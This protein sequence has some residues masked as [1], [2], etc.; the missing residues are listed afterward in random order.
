[1]LLLAT[2]LAS[3]HVSADRLGTSD[4]TYYPGGPSQVSLN[5]GESFNYPW[6]L[7][8]GGTSGVYVN[9]TAEDDLGLAESASPSFAVL[10]VSGWGEID[11]HLTAPSNAAS[12]S[13]SLQVHFTAVN[14]QTN[15]VARQDV[16]VPVS[17]LGLSSADDPTGR[18]LGT[19]PNPLPS[20][21]D[22][23]WAA[24]VVSLL[25]WLG[26]AAALALIVQPI[27]KL[28]VRREKTRLEEVVRILRFPVFVLTL[29]YGAIHSLPILG[30]G[31]DEAL[32]P[33]Y[34]FPVILVLT[35][36]GYHFFRDVLVSYGKAIAKRMKSDIDE[37]LIPAIEKIGAVVIVIVGLILAVQSL[38]Y[39]IT[40]VLAGFGVV[41]LVIAFA[42]QDTVSNFFA[43][44]YIMLD[45]PFRT[46]DMIEIEDDVICTVQDIGLRTTKLY[47]GKNHTSIIMP[48]NE[49]A[50][51]K[52]VNYV[53]PSRHFRANVKV[54]VS[55]HSDLDK[56]K[57]IMLG[58]A[59]AHPWVLK[60][61][62]EY[63]PVFR[64]VDFGENTAFVMVLVWVDDV[65]HK[66]HIGSELRE[67]IKKRFD[68]EGIEISFPQCA[69]A[70]NWR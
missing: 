54:G 55:V 68:K 11:L 50:N 18:I 3:P 52:I 51:R 6:V 44:I 66:W 1:M 17:L 24:F 15:A 34:R 21:L 63:A 48:N 4:V 43:G 59:N 31:T 69:T 33:I 30:L 67:E 22:G 53:R 62:P 12:G 58:V 38:G 13:G 5:L 2:L 23:A 40:L 20:P 19:W 45:R 25:I 57:A 9:L 32:Y 7:F 65:D 36:V 61:D 14:L 60:D 29:L 42:A 8:D 56:V 16:V 47:W 64:V 28:F 70:S 46:G 49:L 37:R 39:D 10:D 41:G 27:V 35:W 26:I